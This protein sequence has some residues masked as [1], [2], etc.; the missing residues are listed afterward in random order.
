MG[1]PFTASG[2]APGLIPP[3]P[4]GFIGELKCVQVDDS[5]MPY[6]QNSLTGQ[7]TLIG[8]VGAVGDV[9]EYNALSFQ[10]NPDT[11]VPTSNDLPLDMV[12]SYG[13]Y[14]GN[15]PFIPPPPLGSGSYSAC[16]A[17]LLLDHFA[18]LLPDMVDGLP[19]TTELTL[20]P[21]QE[22]L[23]NQVTS[24]REVILD[25]YNE[26]ELHLSARLT[27]GCYFHSLLGSIDSRTDPSR[28]T[29]SIGTLGTP[30]AYTRIKSANGGLIGLAEEFRNGTGAAAFNLETEGYQNPAADHIILPQP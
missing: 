21:C 8:T 15:G 25:I 1:R 12:P 29:F 14:I 3:V 2:L 9:S 28:S 4:Q 5:L 20:V 17:V 11:N 30:T 6:R 7:A 18:E 24:S 19:L 10:G 16:P 13:P 26:L 22:N 23:E 27:T